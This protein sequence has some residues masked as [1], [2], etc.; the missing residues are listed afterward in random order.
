MATRMCF[1]ERVRRLKRTVRYYLTT[2][3][4]NLR[5]RSRSDANIRVD[6]SHGARR[7]F[8]TITRFDR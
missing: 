3:P 4:H 8:N 5:D 7:F 2:G 6:D 1:P